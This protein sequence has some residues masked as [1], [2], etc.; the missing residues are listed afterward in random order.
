MEFRDTKHTS[1]YCFSMGSR[2]DLYDFPLCEP[3]LNECAITP[4]TSVIL[5]PLGGKLEI[6]SKDW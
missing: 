4:G 3:E 2:L 5:F 1:S 6:K